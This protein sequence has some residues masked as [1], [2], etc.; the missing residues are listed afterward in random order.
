MPTTTTVRQVHAKA[1]AVRLHETGNALTAKASLPKVRATYGM[2]TSY[3]IMILYLC[4]MQR[5]VQSPKPSFIASWMRES[6]SGS[7]TNGYNTEGGAMA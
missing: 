6:V 5:I 3:Y 4:A 1:R 7:A 2:M